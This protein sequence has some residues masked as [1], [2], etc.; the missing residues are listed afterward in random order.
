[1]TTS[2]EAVPSLAEPVV[3]Q[4]ARSLVAKAGKSS[5]APVLILRAQPSWS[6]PEVID[7]AA[8][9]ESAEARVH[10][11]PC[12]SSL[13]IREA[14]HSLP[15][16]DYLV[17]LSDRTDADLDLGILSYCFDQR[18]VTPSLWEAVRGSFQARHIDSLLTR[19]SWVPEVLIEQT[20]PGGWPVAP[21]GVLTRDHAL[22]HLTA[23][24]LGLPTGDLDPS[25]LLAWTLDS[26][27]AAFRHQSQTVQ[28]GVI[29]WV[30]ETIGP[31]AAL[32][33]TSACQGHSVDAISIG[34]AADVLWDE[35]A[36][37]PDAIAARTRLERWTGV[38]SLQPEVARAFADAARGA[39]QRMANQPG[40][41]H[42]RMMVRATALFD[43]LDYPQGAEQSTVLPVGFDSRL[44]HLA[45]A[46][47]EYLAS[48]ASGT[49]RVEAAFT[50]LLR[51]DAAVANAA[52][53]TARMAVR[54]TRWLA[55][56]DSEP[57]TSLEQAV[58]R[59]AREDAFVDWAAADVWVGS[60]DPEVA[61]AWAALY[62]AVKERRDRHDRE[63]AGLLAD[64]T[65]RGTLP[66]T[67]VPAESIIATTL[68][69][70]AVSAGRAL[71]ILIDGMSTAV[72]AELTEEALRTGWF[73]AVPETAMARTATLAVLPTL[74]RYS[75]TSM[76]AGTLQAGGQSEER[77][78][79]T[80]LTGGQIFHKADL[81][82]A[83]GEALPGAL[84]SAINSD[85]PLHAVVLNTVDDT[86]AKADP[87]GLDWTLPQ[88]RHLQ[89]L[90]DEA[91]R[92]GRAV[93]LISDHGHVVERGGTPL[94]IDGAEARWRLPNG[95]VPD[96]EREIAL[97]GR[98]V[99]AEG[100]SIIAAVDE[101]LRYSTK[102][103]GYH[104][105]A[106]A[107]EAVIPIIVLSRNPDQLASTGWVPA[108]PQV[109]AWWNDEV[110]PA[111]PA[112]TS[113][114]P[115]STR[116]PKDTGPT[117]FDVEER[118]P[119]P[120][121]SPHA[122]LVDEVMGSPIYAAQKAR[123]GAR[124]ASDDLVRAALTVLLRQSGRAHRD[125]VAAA[126]GIPAMSIPGAIVNLRRQLNVEGY[127]VMVTDAD[128][129]TVILNIDLLR[130]QFL[131]GLA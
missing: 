121:T 41:G 31:V 8:P 53:A 40:P 18:V 64:A 129:V 87:G 66:D 94:P 95:S 28:Q 67:L 120:A 21:A 72:A 29:S 36:T 10:I 55:L 104:G 106:S 63:F 89:A 23:S 98:R 17:V 113:A 99:L 123:Y 119:E 117:L 110:A 108:P 16:G 34:L 26:G 47:G 12:V 30:D 7:V 50:R 82:G 68:H 116:K 75:R 32:A 122:T 130:Q 33:L 3:R 45:R 101:T 77:A 92:A 42:A 103:A 76:F 109:P 93:I 43:D 105:G 114:A 11:K 124:A 90:L 54:L 22:S 71:L 14:M 62:E 1:M 56:P 48:P 127:D 19:L 25:M 86:L 115:S 44:R 27:S 51:H 61:S 83:A 88:I 20:P 52:T 9:G 111:T 81:V 60:T 65:S 96:R 49:G 85:V 70:F 6:G 58:Q 15:D 125:T 37:G 35:S 69:P 13:A 74:T 78:G 80:A 100:G 2:T 131:E 79:F 38:R 57:P 112:T 4:Y 118:A 91:G 126:A 5:A 39:S 107:A 46:V 84:L 59:Q 73:E 128:E 97:T 102:Q 24:L